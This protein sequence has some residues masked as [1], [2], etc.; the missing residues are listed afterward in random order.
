MPNDKNQFNVYLPADLIRLVKHQAID[1]Q[2][3]LSD[4]VEYVLRSYLAERN[5]TVQQPSAQPEAGL[6]VM[7][8]IHVANIGTAANFYQKLGAQV[9]MQSRDADWAQLR[10]GAVELG[11]LAHP[12][13]ADDDRIELTFTS[14]ESLTELE[15]RLREAGVVIVQAASDEGFGFQMK[16]QDADGFVI[17][18]NQLEPELYG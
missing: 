1:E 3:S 13:S 4:W 5:E 15:A 17:K 6:R 12:P 2:R 16:V 7:P 9:W 18:I 8:L 10:L 11:L 14:T